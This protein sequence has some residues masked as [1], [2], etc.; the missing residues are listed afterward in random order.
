MGNWSLQ[1]AGPDGSV[2]AVV[3]MGVMNGA[4]GL[5]AVAHFAQGGCL[6]AT[7]TV[8]LA[9]AVGA[10]D[11]LQLTSQPF[12]GTTLAVAGVLAT[13]GGSLGNATY[14]F[15][16]SPCAGLASG[17]VAAAHF[18]AI[19]GNYAGNFTGSTGAVTA[20]S[21]MLQQ[22]SAPDGNGVFHVTGN[23]NFASSA[24]FATQP[25]VTD[26]TISGNSLATT[27]TSGPVT[28]T[29]SGTFSQDAAQLQIT[30]WQI[31]GG[32][33]DGTHGT[34]VLQEAGN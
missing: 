29:A 5:A 16:G 7:T 10:A 18:A 21:A 22:G 30:A 33:C 9:G 19:A 11:E 24:C 14:A 1:L 8:S 4:A 26:S 25:T 23:A 31:A 3:N 20:V 17:T 28:L 34:G 6:P 27:F 12:A 15:N 2:A 32:A 13:G